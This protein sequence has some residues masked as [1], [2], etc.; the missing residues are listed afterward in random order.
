MYL[1]H[2]MAVKWTSG[3]PAAYHSAC[4]FSRISRLYFSVSVERSTSLNDLGRT[5]NIDPPMTVVVLVLVV[6]LDSVMVL[7]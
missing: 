4:I 5:A 6:V 7:V 2:V 3:F 1:S